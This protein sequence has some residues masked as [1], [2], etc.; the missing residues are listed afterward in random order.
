MPFTESKSRTKGTDPAPA[1]SA[2][3]ERNLIRGPRV[4]GVHPWAGAGRQSLARNNQAFF[5]E[6]EKGNDIEMT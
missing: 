6:A 3:Q 1:G 4:Y 2:A 5:G